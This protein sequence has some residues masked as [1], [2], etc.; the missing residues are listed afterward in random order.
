VFFGP[1]V[2][3][4]YRKYPDIDLRELVCIVPLIVFSVLLGVVPGL[5]LNWMEPSVRGLIDNLVTIAK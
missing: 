4:E 3:P 5:L 2:N 1:I